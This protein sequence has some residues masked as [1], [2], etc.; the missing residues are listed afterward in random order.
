MIR[1]IDRA[2]DPALDPYRHVG[3]PAWLRQHDL[4]VAEG[5]LVVERLLDL[6]RYAVQSILLSRAAH[7]GL[8]ARLTS[9]AVDVFVSS[10][11]GLAAITGFNF[12]RG[13]LAL[14]RRP[15]PLPPS[16]LL[17]ASRLLGIEGVG[18]PDNV[19]GLFRAAA[20]FG[21][22]GVL[23][24]GTA[25][26]PLY[27]KAIRVSMGASLRLPFARVPD[28]PAGLRPFR[29]EG[30]TLVALTPRAG[31]P[32]VSAM[33]AGRALLLV[34]AEGSGLRD[35]T[36][37]G[38]DVRLRIPIGEAVDSLNVVVAAAIALY[39]QRRG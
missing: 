9:V 2:D 13:C 20:A 8:A 10:D 19:G 36:L 16:G 7:D 25:G 12:H 14:A 28:W 26:D 6:P 15:A 17:D 21:V 31:V 34:G 5:R 32:A 4:F 11:P 3:D 30:F 33:P 18:N 27:R 1:W 23:L 37:D 39:E 24:D 38:A 35:E 29:D 22:D